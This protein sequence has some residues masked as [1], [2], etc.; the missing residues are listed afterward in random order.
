MLTRTIDVFLD[1]RESG[2]LRESL[3]LHKNVVSDTFLIS[4]CI[5]VVHSF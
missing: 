3:S 5:A 4:K 2:V 1:G